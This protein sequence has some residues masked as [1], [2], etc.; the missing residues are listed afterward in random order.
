MGEIVNENIKEVRR[1]E[2]ENYLEMLFKNYEV[3]EKDR[4]DFDW[5]EPRGIEIL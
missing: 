3:T 5:G 1:A 2:G 4:V